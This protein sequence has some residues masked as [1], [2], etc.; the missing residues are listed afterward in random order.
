MQESWVVEIRDEC[1]AARVPFFFKQWGGTN[2][3]KAGRL[4][5]GRTW[6]EL[7]SLVPRI[8][9]EVSIRD[10]REAVAGVSVPVTRSRRWKP[11]KVGSQEL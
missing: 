7:P 3:K 6:D 2:K 9:P 1:L 11:A 10:R 4:L 5:D 8:Q